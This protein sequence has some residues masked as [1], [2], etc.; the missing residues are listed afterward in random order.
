MRMSSGY[1]KGGS[2]THD[3]S[4][5]DHA[6]IYRRLYSRY[7]DLHWWPGDSRDEILIGAILTQN[8]SWKNVSMAIEKLKRRNLCSLEGIS[9]TDEST[10]QA[11]IRSAGFYRAKAGYLIAAADAIT[12]EYGSLQAMSSLDQ[13]EAE[14]FLSALPGIGP[15][16]RDSIVLYALGMR[17]FVVDAYAMRIFGRVSPAFLHSREEL[18][19]QVLES[20]S[21][22]V[23]ELGNYHAMIV[24]LAK[25]HCKKKPVCKGCPLEAI[26]DYAMDFSS[27]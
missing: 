23:Q 20:G 15:E 9:K 13:G 25:T 14:E 2:G 7:G 3:C 26:C 27:P 19:K 12:G 24:E 21:F 8:T 5:I 11:A 17:S 18:G 4:E 10:L 16:T 6:S 22:T 1:P